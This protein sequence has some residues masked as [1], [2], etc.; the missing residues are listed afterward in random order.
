MSGRL[1][2]EGGG[3]LLLVGGGGLLLAEVPPFTPLTGSINYAPVGNERLP[4]LTRS[5]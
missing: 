3:I 2:L 4:V 5:T 1:A